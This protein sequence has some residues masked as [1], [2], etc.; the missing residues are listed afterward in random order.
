VTR[1]KRALPDPLE[2]A[3]LAALV[4]RCS[5]PASQVRTALEL[6]IEAM[7]LC[8]RYA[9]L[10]L[11]ELIGAF[12]NKHQVAIERIEKK[13]LAWWKDVLELNQNKE[14]DPARDYLVQR[15]LRLKT[16]DKVLEHARAAWN[17]QNNPFLWPNYVIGT[18]FPY[19]IPRGLLDAV[20]AASKSAQKKSRRE[21]QMKWRQK[22]VV[23]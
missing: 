11:E 19:L 3:K 5:T 1:P 8:R 16:P 14:S 6:Y 13:N 23:K 22:K 20:I 12:R 4:P 9:S 2:L 18:K 15:G 7:I 10:S 17:A 21:S